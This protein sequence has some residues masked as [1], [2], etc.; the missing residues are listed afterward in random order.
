MAQLAR[1]LEEK[2]VVTPWDN[3]NWT[4]A[5]VASLVR[6]RV[7][8]GEARAGSIVNPDAHEP[9][10]SLVEWN[11]ANRRAGWRRGA[12]D[13]ARASWRASCAAAGAATR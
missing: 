13:A 4:V 3:E 7:Y 6:N 12:Q 11:A 10:V 9:I 8:L 5:S 2:G 1:F